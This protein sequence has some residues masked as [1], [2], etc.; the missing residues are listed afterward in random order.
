MGYGYKGRSPVGRISG[1]PRVESADVVSRVRATE[2]VSGA[3]AIESRMPPERSF[4][5]VLERQGR[6]LVS[7]EPLPSSEPER[8]LPPPARGADL[9]ELPERIPDSFVGLLWWKMK[10]RL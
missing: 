5:A 10:T 1:L 9:P 4:A 8:P 2:R 7:S 6:G 3:A